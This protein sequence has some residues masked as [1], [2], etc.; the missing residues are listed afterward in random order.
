MERGA[1]TL[2][3]TAAGYDAPVRHKCTPGMHEKLPHGKRYQD[4]TSRKH[5]RTAAR[6]DET[7]LRLEGAGPY[8]YLA[9]VRKLGRCSC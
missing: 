1:W 3:R 9:A 6:R 8:C 7:R 4:G 5:L 2:A